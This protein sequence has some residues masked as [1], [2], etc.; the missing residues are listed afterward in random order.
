[1]KAGYRGA[2]GDLMGTTGWHIRSASSADRESILGLTPRLAE[3]FPLP[4][5]RTPEEVSSAEAGALAVAL[6]SSTSDAIVL[7][8]EGGQG[9]FGGFVYVQRQIDYFRRPHAHVG[10]LAVAAELEG[11]GAGRALLEAAEEWARGQG[12]D[13]ITL[14]VFAGNERARAVYE[15]VDYAPETVR[16]VKQL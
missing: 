9:E 4:R 2:S 6:E 10:I 7:I 8:A 3:G 16:Y 5:W 11:R 14:N 13:M 15:R 12:L 1:M